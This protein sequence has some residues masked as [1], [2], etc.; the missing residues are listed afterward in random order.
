LSSTT[1]PVPSGTY[2]FTVSGSTY[3]H[4]K[5]PL[6][7]AVG[8]CSEPIPVTPSGSSTTVVTELPMAGVGVSAITAA[9]VTPTSQNLLESYDLQMR[10]ATVLLVAPAAVGGAEVVTFTNYEA[11]PAQIKVC[12]IAGA[13]VHVNQPFKFKIDGG[14]FFTVDAGP[15]D[16]GGYCVEVPGTF[17]VGTPVTVTEKSEGTSYAAPVIT[18]NG[19]STASAGCTPVP[20]CVVAEIGP[21]V[22]EMSFTNSLSGGATVANPF[23]SLDIIN[24]SLVRQTAV[25]GTLSYMTYQADLLNTGTTGMGPITASVTSRDSVGIQVVGQGAL[26]FAP[27]PASGQI[28]SSGTFTILANPAVPPDFSKLRWTYQSTRSMAPQR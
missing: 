23:T 4:S 17:Q 21:G 5:K 2:S 28:A 14:D 11:P 24:Y 25:T 19:V 15:L 6:K 10:T 26:K 22:N 7:V 12:K 18:V 9:G 8:G 1:N 27:A 16:Q 13:D 20:R 3:S